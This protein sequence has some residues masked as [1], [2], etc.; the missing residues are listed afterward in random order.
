VLDRAAQRPNPATD[1]LSDA[2]WD[3]LTELE[4]QPV[5]NGLIQSFEQNLSEW[6]GWYMSPKPE[7]EALPGIW[8]NKC[9]E[10]QQMLV[11]RS[12]RLDRV[13][14]AIAKYIATHLG[15]KYIEPPTFNL[16]AIFETATPTVPLIFVLSPGVDPTAQVQQLA[17][18]LGFKFENCAL[19]QGQAPVASRMLEDGVEQGNWVFLANCHLMLS[20]M[21]VRILCTS[22]L[23]CC[24]LEC[25]VGSGSTP[26][27]L[28]AQSCFAH[29]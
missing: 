25:G 1:W 2:G 15:Q 16:K 24:W 9:N 18:T 7:E 28:P 21:P 13:L 26:M 6:K 12:L 19:G 14:F 5:F 11:L 17:A 8:D 29:R 23:G 20:W 27:P 10:L 4:A 22:A 3:N